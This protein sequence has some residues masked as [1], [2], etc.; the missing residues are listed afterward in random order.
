MMDSRDRF[1]IQYKFEHTDI[2]R[3]RFIRGLTVEAFAIKCKIFPSDLRLI[4]AGE[5]N[6][7]PLFYSKVCDGLREI[8]FTDFELETVKRLNK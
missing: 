7:S 6:F 2:K 1:N 5:L 8:N 3:I 4:E